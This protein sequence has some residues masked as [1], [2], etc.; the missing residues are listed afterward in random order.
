[1]KRYFQKNGKY[2]V[3]YL[4]KGEE[5]PADADVSEEA[6]QNRRELSRMITTIPV[7]KETYD[8][9][10]KAQAEDRNNEQ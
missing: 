9:E 10:T 5:L 4:S 2:F 8:R 3:Q 7:S 6:R 1:M